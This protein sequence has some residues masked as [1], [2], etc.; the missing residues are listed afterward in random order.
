MTDNE[1]IRER[2]GMPEALAQLAEEAAELA[3]AAL[4]YRR[5]ITGKNPTPM[6]E[7]EA[8]EHL[9]EEIADVDLCIVVLG[10]VCEEQAAELKRMETK[11]NRWIERIK[12]AEEEPDT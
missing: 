4:K 12:E 9:R 3:Q 8:L 11:R 5:A 6:S 10:D 7:E 2:I 1:F